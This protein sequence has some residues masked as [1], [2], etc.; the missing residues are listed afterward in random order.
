MKALFSFSHFWFSELSHEPL[1]I[2]RSCVLSH[3]VRNI[4]NMEESNF[5]FNIT[6]E[7]YYVLWYVN[8]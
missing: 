2:E 5:I 3:T 4:A 8:I 6:E 7:W 1:P